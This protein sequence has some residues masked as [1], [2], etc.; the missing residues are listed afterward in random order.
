MDIRNKKP[1][2]KLFPLLTHKWHVFIEC[3]RLGIPWRGFTHDLS[4]FLPDEWGPYDEWFY[5]EGRNVGQFHKAYLKH[6]HRN[7]HHWQYWVLRT[8][9][10][11]MAVDMPLRYRKEMLADW[12]GAASAYPGKV[13]AVEWYKK[14][15]TN[16]ILHS[17][18]RLWIEKML[19]LL[20]AIDMEW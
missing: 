19:N 14:E 3:C 18:T 20:P 10:G 2:R 4:K 7:K 9:I 5:G 12:I 16:L 1:W 15:R 6:L 13:T 17:S 11:S 8:E